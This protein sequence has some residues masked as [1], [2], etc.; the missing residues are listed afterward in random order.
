[1]S[2][3]MLPTTNSEICQ[4]FSTSFSSPNSTNDSSNSNDVLAIQ[5]PDLNTFVN[6]PSPSSIASGDNRSER[7]MENL[8]S[9][10]KSK[11]T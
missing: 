8:C 7:S 2:T 9:T 6:T 5:M 4:Q 10:L 11:K 3:K 1:M